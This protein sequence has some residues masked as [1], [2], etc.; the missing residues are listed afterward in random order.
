MSSL[1]KIDIGE[2]IESL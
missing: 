1:S 2:I